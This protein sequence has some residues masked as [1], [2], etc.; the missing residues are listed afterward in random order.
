MAWLSTKLVLSAMILA[1]FGLSGCV[2]TYHQSPDVI[3][4]YKNGS[5]IGKSEVRQYGKDIRIRTYDQRG[6]LKSTSKG[7]TQ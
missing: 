3:R 2:E 7:R 4:H 1:V 6:R 5:Y